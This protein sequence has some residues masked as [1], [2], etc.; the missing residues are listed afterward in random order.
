[1]QSEMLGLARKPKT[2]NLKLWT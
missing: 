1:M 2:A